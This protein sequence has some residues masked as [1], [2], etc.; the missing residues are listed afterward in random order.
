VSEEHNNQN[1]IPDDEAAQPLDTSGDIG[2]EET[3]SGNEEFGVEQLQ[4]ELAES[5]DQ[6]L[7]L[8]AE[9]ENF[10]KRI[11]RERESLIKYA[12]ENILR[13][14]LA[15]IDNLD[16]ALE[17]GSADSDDARQQLDSLLEG[18]ELTQKG[19]LATLEKF[20]VVAIES[21]GKEF[22]PNEHEAMT[23][24]ASDTVPA[25]HVLQEFAK[26]YYFRD[27]LLRPA[28]VVVSQGTE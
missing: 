1:D 4:Q 24:E 11:E 17:Q 25:K 7:R 10:K 8:A 19:L 5:R 21:V 15:T 9:F 28:K 14:L 23:M 3:G 13:E 2:S 12:G 26:G 22:D 27:R 18:V 20:D 16:R 6:V